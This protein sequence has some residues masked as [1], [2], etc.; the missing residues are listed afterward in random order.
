[1]L[2]EK[3]FQAIKKRNDMWSAGINALGSDAIEEDRQRN[4]DQ[5]RLLLD[6]EKYRGG[7][8][9]REEKEKATKQIIEHSVEL[10]VEI[11]DLK[12]ALEK[13][14]AYGEGWVVVIAKEALKVKLEDVVLKMKEFQKKHQ[15]LR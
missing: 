6:I 4:T 14:F 11:A 9:E 15:L 12:E 3:E 8:D 1:M 7:L 10:G 5:Y 13:I 2:S